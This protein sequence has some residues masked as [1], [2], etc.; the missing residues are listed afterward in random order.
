MT[1]NVSE[2]A[3]SLLFHSPPEGDRREVEEDA[4]YLADA[5]VRSF[6]MRDGFT[7]ALIIRENPAERASWRRIPRSTLNII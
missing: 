1:Q 7:H 4:G 5:L 6:H 2:I 3:F